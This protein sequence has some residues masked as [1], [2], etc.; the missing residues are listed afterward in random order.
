ML[1]N[2][3]KIAV[4]NLIKHKLFSVINISGLA[5]G[6]TC[7][8]LIILFVNYESSY[9][10]YHKKAD[11]TYRLAV[12]ALIGDTKIDQTYSSAITFTKLMEDF[13]EI[14]TGVKFLKFND[15]TPVY[16]DKKIFYESKI[17]AVDSVFYDVFTIPFL[18]GNPK[19]VLAEPNSIVL[20]RKSALKY[21]GTVNVV[22][23]IITIFI[24]DE[25]GNV[26]FKISGVSENIPAN[27]HFHYDMLISLTSFPFL[28]DSQEWTRN[29][30]ISYIVL[31]K[32][33]SKD[34]FEEKLKTF[35][36]KYMGGEKYDE[37]VAKGNYWTFY[38]QPL[39]DIHLTSNL[40]GEFEP[41]GNSTYVH[42]FSVIS[43]IILLIA[44][45]NFM[46][47]STAKSSL[48]AKEV[49]LRKVI[50]SGKINLIVQF[51]F[52]S[53]LLSCLAMVISLV[54]VEIIL[55]YYRNFINRPITIN[56]FGSV[57][58]VLVFIF[59]ALLV[60][61]ISGSYPAFVLS[62]FQPIAV[63]KQK[64]TQKSKRFNF[65]NLLLTVQFTISVFL[66]AGTII[67]FKQIQ[68]LQNKNLGF[69][70][71]QVLVI[72]N[73]G[74]IDK[75]VKL[76]K[77]TLYNYNNIIDVS[78]SGSLPGTP[79]INCGF[80]AEGNQ[81]FTLNLC[82]C[83]YN[84]L[85]TL[86]LEMLKGRFFSDEYSSDSVAVI[87]NEKAVQVLG[88]ENPIGKKINS[89]GDN[90]IDFYVI[91]VVKDFHY[92][93]LH[94]TIRPMALFNIDGYYKYSQ[95]YISARVT[96]GNLHETINYIKD[97]W[98]EFAPGAPFEFSFLNDDYNAL[99]NN[100]KQTEQLFTIFS[101]LSIFIAGL[102]L[103]GLASFIAEVKT[104]EIGI[105]KVLGAKITSIVFS[106]LKEFV[107]W[108]VIA[109]IIACPV[110]Y[111]FMNEWLSDFAYRIDISWWVFLIAGCTAL[112]IAL[113]TVSYQAIKAAMANPVE[114][115]RYE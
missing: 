47:L 87:L 99:Y 82:L 36:R 80:G 33:T 27:S 110:V 83:D 106:I 75:N 58:T 25:I 61:I 91:G 1:K 2:Y 16:I 114:A 63:L 19:T 5:I 94:Q 112:V 42:I 4:R 6:I 8:I 30:F 40:N 41:N 37:W 79:F 69:E 60:G 92:E 95:S 77:Q 51:L 32:G 17:Y 48:R 38:L 102:G 57:S 109:I 45:I 78:G 89:L 64:L 70:K 113:V 15:P 56:Y 12:S 107:K 55:P 67:V 88:W 34:N 74:T 20:S 73:P 7:S 62:S 93:S 66:I 84:F 21:F 3:L 90:G 28:L 39:T 23:K 65:R 52:E 18:K 85:N 96:T 71:E 13:P 24:D 104:K 59:G 68:F 97:K 86:K 10:A 14:E 105:K 81:G 98:N 100:E 26:D 11:R 101:L 111:Y 29:I 72:K 43:I 9:D 35:T 49:G 46:N 50:G 76:F 108:I 53:V 44:C 115:L 31:K 54:L 22:G 103:Y